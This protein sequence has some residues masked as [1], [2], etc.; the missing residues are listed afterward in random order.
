MSS[1]FTQHPCFNSEARHNAGRIHLPVAERCNLQCNFCNRKYDCSNESRPGVT[2]V[3]LNPKQALSYLDAAVEKMEARGVPLTVVGIA[4]PG[5]PFANPEATLQT[6]ELVRGKYPEKIL[7]LSSNGLGLPDYVDRIAA[8]NV[9]H[10]TVTINA[11]DPEIGARIY[12]WVR[13][14]PRGYRGLDGARI[15]LQRQTEAIKLLKK[16][17]ITVKI[18]T[19]IIPGVNDIHAPDVAA[20][21]ANLGADIQNNMPMVP[22][23]G[24]AFENIPAPTA[25]SIAVIR[26][27]AG[28]F[29]PQM[30]HCARC[31]ADAAGLIG[32]SNHS[33]I[34]RLLAE[35]AAVKTSEDKPYVAVA[36]MEGLFVN[37]HLGEAAGLYI[38]GMEN[39]KVTLVEQRRTPAPGSGDDRWKQLAAIIDDC[40]VLLVGHCGQN[41]HK[42]LAEQGVQVIVT[43]GL[44]TDIAA[45]I[46]EGREIP[47]I[48]TT[49]RAKSGCAGT[50]AGCS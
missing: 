33:D 17:G 26:S 19:V 36:S 24:A 18:N 14:G 2:S 46:L 28:K 37:R 8:F 15:L 27:F 31:R 43:E 32:C 38:Y 39:G 4:G 3:L 9:S 49:P 5:D 42:V 13:L 7:C 12:P 40:S 45:P 34:D 10:V 47:K 20:Y 35:A 41:P 29:I 6:L 50:G 22:V 11:I 21:A 48:F 16:K 30:N 44:I 23:E 1:D 25:E